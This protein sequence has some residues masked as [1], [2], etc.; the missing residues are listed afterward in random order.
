MYLYLISSTQVGLCIIF[1]PTPLVWW[2]PLSL[3][4]A[5]TDPK[6]PISLLVEKSISMLSV[7]LSLGMFVFVAIFF[8]MF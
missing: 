6:L 3:L 8:L 1:Y 7:V 5:T 2:R 4:F